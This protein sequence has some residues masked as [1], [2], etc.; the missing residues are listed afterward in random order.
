MAARRT[1]RAS[2]TTGAVFMLLWSVAMVAMV[3]ATPGADGAPADVTFP[4]T[5]SLA[6]EPGRSSARSEG[7]T[8][9]VGVTT[10]ALQTRLPLGGMPTGPTGYSEARTAEGGRHTPQDYYSENVL[11]AAR[12][13]YGMVSSVSVEG[14]HAY[15]GAGASLLVFDFSDPNRLELCG[16]TRTARAIKDVFFSGGLAY[17]A[18][19]DAGLTIVDVSTA[20]DPRELVALDTAG[21]AHAVYVQDSRA[22]L[23]DGNRG[24]RILDVSDLSHPIEVGSVPFLTPAE[25][26]TLLGDTAYVLMG[27]CRGLS[28]LD[29]SD[30]SSPV[31][32]GKYDV[33]AAE[34]AGY[35]NGNA[36]YVLLTNLGPVSV[37]DVS[38]PSDP[39]VAGSMNLTGMVYSI[40]VADS[41]AYVGVDNGLAV[42]DLSDPSHPSVM[43]RMDS[44]SHFATDVSI[45]GG[46]ACVSGGT[47]VT[48]IDTSDPSAPEEKSRYE[49]VG[50]LEGVS[51]SNNT[52]FVSAGWEGLCMV[53]VSNPSAPSV[54]SWCKGTFVREV[55]VSGDTAFAAAADSGLLILN[56]ADPADPV[57][58]GRYQSPSFSAR[59]VFVAGSYAYVTDGSVQMMVMD[60]SD[61]SNPSV[62]GSCPIPGS[63]MAA[64]ASGSYVYVLSAFSGIHVV[65]VS[66]RQNPVVVR[67][68]SIG[69]LGLALSENYL[70]VAAEW[71]GLSILDVSNP[72]EP[73]E[74]GSFDTPGYAWAVSVAGALAYVAD[75]EGGLRVI[76][77]SDPSNPWEAGFHLTAAFAKDVAASGG[78]AYVADAQDGLW[79]FEVSPTP[80]SLTIPS[81]SVGPDGVRL[82]W[83]SNGERFLSYAI[84]RAAAGSG[85]F[86]VVGEVPHGESTTM[87]FI[88]KTAIPGRRY[89][90]RV[91]AARSDGSR[92]CS[93]QVAVI[94]RGNSDTLRLSGCT[95]NP[96][97]EVTH[98]GYYVGS[99]GRLR[100]VVY[101]VSGILVK[102]LKDSWVAAGPGEL[103]WDGTDEYRRTVA[104]GVYYLQVQTKE[105]RQR[106]KVTLLK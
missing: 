80:V 6:R 39:F 67:V 56:V 86:V 28:I 104:S 72:L 35:A 65:D 50:G 42:V 89:L 105:K 22:Y 5:A 79:V 73:T 63:P 81:P 11:L 62:V 14:S 36:R 60:V 20:C 18:I 49:F 98:L 7:K 8:T 1:F 12:L 75:R 33:C 30:P 77:V 34:I 21:E 32:L 94:A 57:E 66:D 58:I 19:G 78:Y 17:A 2:A 53:D 87:S 90:Y 103:T 68:I 99:S 45:S 106:C 102:V 71:N 43:S 48:I 51:V 61:P 54:L 91:C 38:D 74:V 24:L 92:I 83:S 85:R 96:F 97:N 25:D 46:Y 101:D 76:N 88:D 55:V 37:L 69:A 70:Y 41:C 27:T 26:V 52:A 100:A 84:E 64:V 93:S 47:G 31:E 16:Y 44:L 59:S 40:S 10:S 29:V 15:V 23:A 95:P 4:G 82:T 9:T 13:F 3:R